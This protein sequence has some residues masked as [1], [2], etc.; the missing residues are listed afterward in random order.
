VVYASFPVL[1]D[2]SGNVV[3]YRT[4]DGGTSWSQRGAT[5]GSPLDQGLLRDFEQICAGSSSVAEADY[6]FAVDPS[7]PDKVWIGRR[8]LYRSGRWSL[9][10]REGES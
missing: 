3:I 2:T 9:D 1:A 4:T 8:E 10:V 5:D 6:A 7:D